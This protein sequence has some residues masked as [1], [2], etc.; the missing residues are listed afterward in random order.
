VRGVE[1]VLAAFWNVAASEGV[2][3]KLVSQ[4]GFAYPNKTSTSHHNAGLS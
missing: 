2:T 3:E 4:A 1:A